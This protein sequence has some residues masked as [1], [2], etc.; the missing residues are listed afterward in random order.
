MYLTRNG[1]TVKLTDVTVIYFYPV[2]IGCILIFEV[3]GIIS[4]KT[5][6]KASYRLMNSGYIGYCIGNINVVGGYINV[7][8]VSADIRLYLCLTSGIVDREGGNYIHFLIFF[9]EA[10]HQKQVFVI[11]FNNRIAC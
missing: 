2:Y 9:I 6:Y 5:V 4:G 11:H 3:K 10:V 1:S 8:T 7:F